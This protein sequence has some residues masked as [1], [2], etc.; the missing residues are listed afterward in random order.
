MKKNL[1][2]V[3]SLCAISTSVFAFNYA[4]TSIYVG[5]NS[6]FEFNINMQNYQ[7]NNADFVYGANLYY[8]KEDISTN[9]NA[10]LLGA[11]V[12]AGYGLVTNELFNTKI[13][14]N[15]LAGLGLANYKIS[16][17]NFSNSKSLL[18]LYLGANALAFYNQFNYG[19]SLAYNFYTSSINSYNAD[20]I[21]LK[22][23]TGYEFANNISANAYLAYDNCLNSSVKFGLGLAYKF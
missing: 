5:S 9:I 21:E 14:I 2:S 22:L 18:N 11:R 12:L 8:K 3:L 10:K 23:H 17:F 15:A 4:D 6:A 13:H 19:L 7:E 1:L 16:I 20:G